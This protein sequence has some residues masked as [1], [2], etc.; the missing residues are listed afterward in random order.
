MRVEE[1]VK[2]DE[3]KKQL[4]E[5][6][7][8]KV[9]LRAQVEIMGSQLAEFRAYSADEVAKG[10]SPTINDVKGA[11]SKAE[12]RVMSEVGVLAKVL[13]DIKG[14]LDAAGLAT[15]NSVN[16]PT[17]LGSVVRSLETIEKRLSKLEG[18]KGN[19]GGQESLVVKPTEKNVQERGVI[20]EYRGGE[21]D[22]PA[23]NASLV[24]A[25]MTAGVTMVASSAS[26]VCTAGKVCVHTKYK[27]G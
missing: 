15:E 23:Q 7:K 6:G 3:L 17:A 20:G 26:Y 1:E 19:D 9:A 8:E 14:S 12:N 22:Q 13:D 2:L 16:I 18:M 10:L 25:S 24:T 4:S 11:V 5:L 27:E 21:S